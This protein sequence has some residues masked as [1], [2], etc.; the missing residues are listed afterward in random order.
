MEILAF[1][2]FL[3]LN[4]SCNC[5]CNSERNFIHESEWGENEILIYLTT[6]HSHVLVI[7]RITK[8]YV[9]RIEQAVASEAAEKNV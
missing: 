3:H 1:Q 7:H 8:M 2:K 9:Q 6:T 4:S 5:K